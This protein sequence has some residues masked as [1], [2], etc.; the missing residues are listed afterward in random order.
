M[1]SGFGSFWALSERAEVVGAFVWLEDV[2]EVVDQ[3]P[4]AADVRSPRL[5]QHGLEP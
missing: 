3:V 4:Q 2:G 1:Q 5:T